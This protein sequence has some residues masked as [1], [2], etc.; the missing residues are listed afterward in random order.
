MINNSTE[1]KQKSSPSHF[2]SKLFISS[3]QTSNKTVF[4]PPPPNKD[5]SETSFPIDQL[6]IHHTP[7]LRLQNFL[8]EEKKNF[9]T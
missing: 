8:I 2:A 3:I 1:I 5:S 6:I 9:K 4:L 7:D